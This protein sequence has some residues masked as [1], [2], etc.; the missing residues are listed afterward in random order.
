MAYKQQ[1]AIINNISNLFKISEKACD[2]LI[3]LARFED[4]PM[5]WAVKSLAL[6]GIGELRALVKYIVSDGEI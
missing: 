3:G 2:I 6:R 1:E 4:K 5:K